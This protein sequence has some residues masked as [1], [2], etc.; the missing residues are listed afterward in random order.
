MEQQNIN[1]F[2]GYTASDFKN[3]YI[4]HLQAS[5]DLPIIQFD[6]ISGETK[7]YIGYGVFLS[8][9]D[10]LALNPFYDSADFF[11]DRI[12]KLQSESHSQLEQLSWD[13]KL[14]KNISTFL[15]VIIL[16]IAIINWVKI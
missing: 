3:A 11:R 7:A 13:K 9:K 12:L 4:H 14:Y 10:F 8:E 1:P 2:L 16:A 5:Q 6:R 15:F